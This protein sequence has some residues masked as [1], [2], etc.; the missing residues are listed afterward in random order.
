[1]NEN[2][3]ETRDLGGLFAGMQITFEVGKAQ[4]GWRLHRRPGRR[5]VIYATLNCQPFGDCTVQM[6]LDLAIAP[7]P[8][9][10]V[11]RELFELSPAETRMAVRLAEGKTLRSIAA[12][13]GIA[14]ST[15][16]THLRSVFGK[17]ATNRQTELIGLLARIAVLFGTD[18]PLRPAKRQQSSLN[19]PSS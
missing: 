3:T 15:A 14:V 19:R 16:R 12:E 7:R 2:V 13:M 1:M 8:R 4:P 11:L 18:K 10:R 5:P 6:A 9:G 17:T